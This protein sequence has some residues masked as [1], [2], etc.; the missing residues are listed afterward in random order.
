V[1][2]RI[3]DA[4]PQAQENEEKKMVEKVPK[5]RK[6]L[7]KCFFK[8]CPCCKSVGCC[9][10]K[11][12]KYL[13]KKRINEDKPG[14]KQKAFNGLKG[15]SKKIM[16]VCMVCLPLLLSW[17]DAF[18]K[19]W[20]INEQINIMEDINW[21]VVISLIT[22]I[23]VERLVIS[24]YIAQKYF[25]RGDEKSCTRKFHRAIAAVAQFLYLL[26]LWDTFHT[27]IIGPIK[28]CCEN[29]KRKKDKGRRSIFEYREEV[30]R[31][32][33]GKLQ[34]S[35]FSH[36]ILYLQVIY[37]TIPLFVVQV[38]YYYVVM[39][40]FKCLS[41]DGL[42]EEVD[43]CLSVLNVYIS[44]LVIGYGLYEN[45]RYKFD[46]CLPGGF[47]KSWKAQLTRLYCR[48]YEVMSRVFV[49]YI[50]LTNLYKIAGEITE[51]TLLM[52]AA[53]W[54][55]MEIILFYMFLVQWNEN[56]LPPDHKAD[57]II[58]LFLRYLPNLIYLA[59]INNKSILRW[60]S[61]IRAYE[62][63]YISVLG[64]VLVAV[65]MIFRKG[66]QA[67]NAFND[68]L[69]LPMLLCFLMWL[70]FWF[71]LNIV[72]SKKVKP[73]KFISNNEFHNAILQGS[74]RHIRS[75]VTRSRRERLKELDHKKMNPLHCAA[76]V[77]DTETFLLI[78]DRLKPQNDKEEDWSR[79][80][81]VEKVIKTGETV[82]HIAAK[83]LPK[84]NIR[85]DRK[86]LNELTKL[87]GKV[88]NKL[89]SINTNE[90]MEE[91]EEKRPQD[92]DRGAQVDDEDR[93]DMEKYED[94]KYSFLIGKSDFYLIKLILSEYK[95]HSEIDNYEDHNGRRG[96][97]A[98]DSDYHTLFH[99]AAILG[100]HMAV[101]LL[102]KESERAKNH[103]VDEAPDKYRAR[104]QD[105]AL[106]DGQ[107]NTCLHLAVLASKT[108]EYVCP[109]NHELCEKSLTNDDDQTQCKVCDTIIQKKKIVWVCP[110]VRVNKMCDFTVCDDCYIKSKIA[111]EDDQKTEGLNERQASSLFSQKVVKKIAEAM[112]L[113][114]LLIANTDKK[115]AINLA[116]E[117][118][119][120]EAALELK[121][122]MEMKIRDFKKRT[123]DCDGNPHSR[124]EDCLSESE[125]GLD[126]FQ[127]CFERLNP[128]R[129][130]DSTSFEGDDKPDKALRDAVK[131]SLRLYWGKAASKYKAKGNK[132]EKGYLYY[133][134][135]YFCNGLLAAKRS[136][137]FFQDRENG[138]VAVNDY[139]NVHQRLLMLQSTMSATH[140]LLMQPGHL[141][142]SQ[143]RS[144]NPMQSESYRY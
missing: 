126:G 50:Y 85:V 137:D 17:M 2:R 58:D 52:M 39:R 53:S 1:R 14:L 131:K 143:N 34:L 77:S 61:T 87:K 116:V 91:G 5:C 105:I 95:Q 125:I 6:C 65:S 23:S 60:H 82:L 100:N 72:L 15:C 140:T 46:D 130:F 79:D 63:F 25:T 36:R 122:I 11:H 101:E 55:I 127:E 78:L 64:I 118:G 124:F 107:G 93:E 115:M 142:V 119:K 21:V 8:I 43:N 84:E 54:M 133:Y 32:K 27:L 102:L 4:V 70:K 37:E 98:C 76:L 94:L 144:M 29:R 62:T 13:K 49:I 121:R 56:C 108:Q 81:L 74:N 45:D 103:G 104:R 38:F 12:Q 71:L 42:T 86:S 68:D 132:F 44:V 112:T 97:I 59:D 47:G 110:E 28:M 90:T 123:S 69:I 129:N 136:C 111:V 18:S 134:V 20:I 75:L 80:C 83:S 96:L 141:T 24:W 139:L 30:R 57:N 106:I 66:N 117:K 22:V 7:Y 51:G 128:G 19:A 31:A 35:F 92:L 73:Q 9:K 40:D 120:T 89:D 33:K 10:K 88:E 26:I 41:E 114:Q 48:I 135:H 113:P 67:V 109:Q 99:K 16:K 138:E 3:D